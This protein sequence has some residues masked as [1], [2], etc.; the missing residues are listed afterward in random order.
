MY[1]D[2][3]AVQLSKGRGLGLADMLVRQLQRMGAIGAAAGAS[4]AAGSSGTGA[5]TAGSGTTAAL[6][7]AKAAVPAASAA[8]EQNFIKGLWPQA[9]QAGQELGV[10]PTNLL[11]QAALETNWGRSMP[12]DS[13]GHSSNNLF[14]VKATG[15]W[16]GATVQ[17]VTSEVDAAGTA[18]SALAPFRSYADATQSFQDYVS[19]LRSNPRYAGALNT[20]SNAQ[21]FA[22][23]LQRGGYATDPDYVRKVSAVASNISGHLAMNLRGL[24]ALKS[25]SELPTTVTTSTL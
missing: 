14:G 8:T 12:H 13:S 1:D 4:G 11:A 24:T 18:R 5:S 10:D 9:Q 17:S 21:A 19:L 16:N 6:P 7:T 20:G 23:G 2:Q 3:L 25:G 15:S 22:A